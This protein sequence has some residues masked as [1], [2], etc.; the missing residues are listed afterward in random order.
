MVGEVLCLVN[1]FHIIDMENKLE[2]IRIFAFDVL[3]SGSFADLSSQT[4]LLLKI[5]KK[6]SYSG[7]TLTYELSRVIC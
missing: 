1:I 6:L 4:Y 2:S 5:Q 3:V 7:C